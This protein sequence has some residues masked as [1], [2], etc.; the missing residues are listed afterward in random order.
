MLCIDRI[1][2]IKHLCFPTRLKPGSCITALKLS[3]REPV[4]AV[5]TFLHNPR[6]S[7]YRGG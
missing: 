6:L 5:D 4:H 1:D 7:V 3:L 2:T